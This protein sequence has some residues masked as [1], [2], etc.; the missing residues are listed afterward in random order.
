MNAVSK[1]ENLPKPTEAELGILNVLW[2][3]GPSTVRQVPAPRMCAA[4]GVG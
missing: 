1:T 2:E 4:S 3:R